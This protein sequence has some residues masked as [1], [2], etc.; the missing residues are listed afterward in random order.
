[1]K[2]LNSET[3]KNILDTMQRR[4]NQKVGEIH[5]G[6]GLPVIKRRR[7]IKEWWVALA[8]RKANKGAHVVHRYLGHK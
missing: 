4:R 8:I 7:S 1:M 6:T 2:H 3:L 5:P